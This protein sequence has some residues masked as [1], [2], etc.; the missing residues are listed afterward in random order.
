[1][2]PPSGALLFLIAYGAG[3][4]TGLL[5]FSD[6]RLVTMVL[7]AA[8]IILRRHWWR[9]AVIAALLGFG[10][11]VLEL[12]ARTTRCTDHLPLGEQRYTVVL[13]DPGAGSGRVTLPEACDGTVMARWPAIAKVQ[14]GDTAS[15]VAR[16]LPRE[17]ALGFSQGMLLVRSVERAR[18]SR[19]A[20]AAL[21]NRIAETSESLYGTQSPLVEALIVGWRGELAPEI[22][23]RFASAGLVHL[24]AISG[25]H[26]GLLA[27]WALLGLRLLGVPRHSA[28]FGAAAVAIA[29]AVFLGWPPPAARAATLA[30]LLA[31]TRWRQRQV[32]PSALLASS[33]S[34]VLLTNPASLVSVGAW[35]SILALGGLTAATRWSDRAIG[36]AGWIRALSGSVGA[37]VA[38]APL[39]AFVFGQVAPIGI[40]LN[41]I[42]VPLAAALVP[43][44]LASLLLFQLLPMTATAFAAS[45][46]LL[47]DAL[48]RVAAVGSAL[49]GA[50]VAGG[51]GL[52]DALPWAA[53][54]LLAAWAMHGRSTAPEALRRMGWGVTGALWLLLAI[55]SRG[56]PVLGDGRLA[57]VFV[58]VGQG[59][60]A[61][62]RTPGGHWVLAD[63]GP[64]DARWDAGE[65]VILPLLRRQGVTRL[66][67]VVISHAHRDHV[68]GAAAITAAMQIGVALEPGE[69]VSEQ[70]YHRWLE[71]L[72]RR[73][74][75]WQPVSAG[76]A[77]QIDGVR[78]R[79]LHPPRHWARAGEDLN[80]D[81]AIL[82]VAW[83]RFTALLMG[84]AGLVAEESLAG[85]VGGVDVLKVGHHGSRTASGTGFLATTTPQVAV[86]S[87]GRNRYGHPT[88][89]ALA[90]LRAV[91]ARIWR[92]DREGQV[93]VESDGQ[94]FTVR[95]ARG[96]TTFTA[97]H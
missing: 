29:Y 9:M 41:L 48:Q 44:L 93:T 24:L 13:T 82:E 68:G 69:A 49:P 64:A 27:A 8:T 14:A 42:A 1:M 56:H 63:A 61:L 51:G 5:H 16:W 43:A 79:V 67:A 95:G 2:S 31:F 3:L 86:V 70:S 39:T 23:Q 12:R 91:G 36:R 73:G 90:R 21:R 59:D 45:G 55:Q 54:L 81:S 60:A 62:I 83:G 17:G 50:A 53:A 47:L 22:R 96:S 71:E 10:A 46:G 92:T 26:I 57:L 28:E 4:V 65:R 30:V 11:S 80:E 77:W 18:P 52:A 94:T 33:A 75:R 58:D 66:E 20:V 34:V 7:V 40:L 72:A 19:S 32:I 76:M 89:E 97:G 38:T 15:V 87:V 37:M 74:V 85:V 88:A 25:F 6:P 78:F 35:L 84:D